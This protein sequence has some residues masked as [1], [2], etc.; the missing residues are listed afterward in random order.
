MLKL[1]PTTTK[2][3]FYSSF[4]HWNQR[5]GLKDIKAAINKASEEAEV[6]LEDARDLLIEMNGHVTDSLAATEDKAILFYFMNNWK[7]ILNATVELLDH[8]NRKKLA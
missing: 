7:P 3:K 4:Y 5:E 8:A 2:A 6:S 1:L